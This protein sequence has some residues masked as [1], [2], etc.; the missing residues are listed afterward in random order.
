MTVERAHTQTQPMV[1]QIARQA[2][3]DALTYNDVIHTQRLI[4]CIEHSN[5]VSL[6]A[7]H[8]PRTDAQTPKWNEKHTP[9][10]WKARLYRNFASDHCKAG[11][12]LRGC[13]A[14][15]TEARHAAAQA[16]MWVANWVAHFW[17]LAR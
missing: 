1:N 12:R 8:G 16:G 13:A 11:L 2:R 15:H 5:G 17:Y 10:K 6:R 3:D 4:T 7:S 14:W 9:P